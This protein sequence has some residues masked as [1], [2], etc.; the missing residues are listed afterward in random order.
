MF[1]TI[2]GL[3]MARTSIDI[4]CQGGSLSNNTV[5]TEIIAPTHGSS[6]S[7]NRLTSSLVT[8]GCTVPKTLTLISSHTTVMTAE[9]RP[10]INSLTLTLDVWSETY[11]AVHVQH[12]SSYIRRNSSCTYTRCAFTRALTR[13]LTNAGARVPTRAHAT[14]IVIMS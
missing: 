2:V 14:C 12:D 13:I 10:P 5:Q 11:H 7:S 4:M 1:D 8:S 9:G 6:G 3:V